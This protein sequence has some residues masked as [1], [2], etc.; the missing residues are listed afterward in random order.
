LKRLAFVALLVAFAATAGQ[1]RASGG[2]AI[3]PASTSAPFPVKSY[4][5]TLPRAQKLRASDIAVTENRRPVQDVHIVPAS[6]RG[7][8]R[9]GVVLAVDSS[10]SMAGVGIN[11]AMQAARAFEIHRAPS[12]EF[13][14]LTFDSSTHPVL[15]FTTSDLDIGKALDH[16]PPL[17]QGTHIYDA[18][19][20][21]VNMLRQAHVDSGSIVLLSDGA[22]VGG[23]S[24]LADAVRAA[25]ASHIRIFTVGLRSSSFRPASLQ[26]LAGRTGGSY[27]ERSESNPTTLAPLFQQL[28][29]RLGNQYLVRYLSPAGPRMHVHV[30]MSVAGVG[31]AE[32]SYR[33]PPLAV[34]AGSPQRSAFDRVSRSPITAALVILLCVLLVAFAV[35]SLIEPSKSGIQRRMSEFVTLASVK[36]DPAGVARPDRA[37][38]LLPGAERSL[39]DMAW[40][41]RFKEE[42]EIAEI[43]TP[44]IQLVALT[45]IAT[46]GAFILISVVSGSVLYALVAFVIPVGVRSYCKR[47]LDRRRQ[48]FAN[49]LPDALEIVASALR[50]GHG[51]VAALAVVVDGAPEPMKSELQRVIA[52]EQL[53]AT[54]DDALAVVV[55][56]MDNRD[57]EQLA[58]VARL[59]RETGISAAEVIDRVT[60]TVR[61]RFELRRLVKTL[62]AQGRLSRWIVSALPLALL[63]ILLSANSHYLHPLVVHTFGKVL[64]VFSALLVIGGSWVIGK[65][66]D[67][68]V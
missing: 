66:V 60:E 36:D 23:S 37:G 8:A 50:A 2:V 35:G 6:G 19:I 44:A 51:L 12:Q 25:R 34:S 54:L 38:V 62:T 40:W 56:R 32:T 58:Y 30:A 67:I 47:Q 39:Q 17:A 3:E 52:A 9:F 55:T 43:K 68:K 59:Q 24:S 22:D 11:G 53:G 57:L 14:F 4:V 5:L 46:I 26:A 41:E 49:Q 42:L 1:A 27:A 7:A 65:I 18:A 31:T 61:E 10:W 48:Q 21:A 45:V 28:A 63:L 15:P 13:A 16:N 64:L 20:A 29:V 33:S